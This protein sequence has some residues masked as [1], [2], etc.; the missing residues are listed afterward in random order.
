MFIDWMTIYQDYEQKLPVVSGERYFIQDTITG[1]IVRDKQ[2]PIVHE[3]S[4][5]TSIKIRISDNRLEVSGNPSRFNRLDNFEGFKTLSDCI[6]VYNRVLSGLGLPLFT[7]C[8]RTWLG[9]SNAKGKFP[10]VSDG[11]CFKEIHLT[12]NQENGK[13][14]AVTVIRA[15][16]TQKYKNSI[17]NLFTDNN[18]VT[19]SSKLGN[20]R[21]LRPIVYNKGYELEL[22]LLP[23]IKKM[24]GTDSEEFLYVKNLITYC[25]QNG[26]TRHELNLKSE[27]LSR[28]SCKFWGLFKEDFLRRTH[29]DF[30]KM[31]NK[32]QVNHLEVEDMS[33]KLLRLGVCRSRQSSNATSLYYLQWLHGKSFD[34]AKAAVKTHRA[35]LRSIGIDIASPADLTRMV[36]V[37]VVHSEAVISKPAIAPSWYRHPQRLNG[38]KLVA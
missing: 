28:N 2:C 37:Q 14:R 27:W 8:T 15:L 24:F 35:R 1:E 10:I 4:F 26:I 7:K 23:K 29:E 6:D 18:S 21:L 17:P 34:L 16:S 13:G 22:H 11:A 9:K 12:S 20:C 33:D 19:W 25:H 30:L 5:S 3:G 31:Q 36:S 38:L 32:L